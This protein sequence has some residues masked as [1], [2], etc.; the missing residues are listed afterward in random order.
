MMF[1]ENNLQKLFYEGK[2]RKEKEKSHTVKVFNEKLLLNNAFRKLFYAL[3]FEDHHI[4]FLCFFFLKAG[5]LEIFNVIIIFILNASRA[6]KYKE[7]HLKNVYIYIP[8]YIH[9]CLC[10]SGH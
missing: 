9:R 2:T 4:Y 10:R 5:L 7:R 1:L 8:T 6:F 3:V